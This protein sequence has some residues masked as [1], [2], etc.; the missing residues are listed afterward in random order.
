MSIELFAFRWL[1]YGGFNFVKIRYQRDPND[2]WKR[3][4]GFTVCEV[5]LAIYWMRR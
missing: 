1:E 3:G 4:L 2:L 5:G